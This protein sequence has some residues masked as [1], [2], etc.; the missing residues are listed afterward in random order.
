[1]VSTVDAR[2]YVYQGF[3]DFTI[4]I[5]IEMAVGFLIGFVTYIIFSAI[6][7]AGQVIDMETGLGIVNVIDRKAACR[8]RLWAI[9]CTL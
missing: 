6:Y 8:F 3:G 4:D 2:P 5:A 9:S 7:V 1:M